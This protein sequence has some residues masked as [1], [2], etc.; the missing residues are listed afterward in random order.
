MKIHVAS[1]DRDECETAHGEYKKQNLL[2]KGAYGQVF[3][4]CSKSRRRHP[5]NCGYVLKIQEPKDEKDIDKTRTNFHREVTIHQYL[6]THYPGV[7]P[8]LWDSWSCGRDRFYMVMDKWDETLEALLWKQTD[9]LVH[10]LPV[11]LRPFVKSG[12][13]GVLYKSQLKAIVDLIVTLSMNAQIVHGD[14]HTGNIFYKKKK[15]KSFQFAL[16]DLG[17][18]TFTRSKQ[19][20]LENFQWNYE[21][22]CEFPNDRLD[23]LWDNRQE[24]NLFQFEC[25]LTIQAKHATVSKSEYDETFHDNAARTK[26]RKEIEKREIR[27][28][29]IL[30]LDSPSS[31]P[32]MEDVFGG[33][34]P[35]TKEMFHMTSHCSKASRDWFTF[36]QSLHISTWTKYDLLSGK[37]KRVRVTSF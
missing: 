22:A 20:F 2:G 34:L 1:T 37:L 31:K 19:E 15:N 21:V 25:A 7:V 17:L 6:T 14:L 33:F 24:L 35:E 29:F 23:W 36:I 4:A 32:M 8:R 10:R 12:Q 16:A 11:S 18:A 26:Q 3:Q 5:G 27:N 30:L 9:E 28:S 13:L